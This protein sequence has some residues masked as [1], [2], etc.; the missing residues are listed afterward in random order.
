MSDDQSY[1]LKIDV[2]SLASLPMARLAEYMTEFARLLGEQERVHFTELRP[3]SAIVVCGVE[4]VA[5]PK[6]AERLRH[7]RDGT[8]PK[9][10]LRAFRALDL[11]LVNDNAVASL[12]ADGGAEIIIFPGRLGPKPTRYGPFREA[13]SLDGTVIRL[14]GRDESVPILLKDLE[15]TEHRC[16]TTIAISRQLAQHYLGATLRVHGVGKWIREA[17]GSWTLQQF[18]ISNFEGIDDAP[19][20]DVVAK[21]RAIGGGEWQN[22]AELADVIGLRGAQKSLH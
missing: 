18:D 14:G 7:I 1:Q 20:V 21:L 4:A 6:V 16:Q 19:L 2:F 13:G 8:A 11:L 5:V 17:T 15:G 10:A 22:D 3:G 9:D 12:S